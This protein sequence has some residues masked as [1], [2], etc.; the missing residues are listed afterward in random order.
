MTLSYILIFAILIGAVI[1]WQLRQSKSRYL[2]LSNQVF[3]ELT[4]SILISKKERKINK[5]NVRIYA[6]KNVT[7]ERIK[8]ELI[9]P[10]REFR[11]IESPKISNLISLPFNLKKGT[12]F[13]VIFPYEE[14][15]IAITNEMTVLNSF[16][17]VIETQNGKVFKSHEL[18]LDKFWKIYK[19]DSGKYN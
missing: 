2:R 19:A 7:I 18:K 1:I 11:Y 17:V 9:S 13:D 4:L 5:L 12:T 8:F 15:K 10:K 16:R 6:K 3:P 14:F